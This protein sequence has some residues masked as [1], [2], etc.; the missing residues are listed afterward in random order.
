ML[1][2]RSARLEETE[3]LGMPQQRLEARSACL[4]EEAEELGMPQQLLEFSRSACL[5]EEAEE[6]GM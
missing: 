2:A 6:L 5:K 4:K 3:E 1:E